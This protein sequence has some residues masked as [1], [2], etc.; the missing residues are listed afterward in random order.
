[1]E[2]RASGRRPLLVSPLL[3]ANPICV[4]APLPGRAL[5]ACHIFAP[6]VCLVSGWRCVSPLPSHTCGLLYFVVG[7]IGLDSESERADQTAD[8]HDARTKAQGQ[9][10]RQHDQPSA[11]MPLCRLR[12]PT[13][14]CASLRSSFHFCRAVRALFVPTPVRKDGALWRGG[15]RGLD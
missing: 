4:R 15:S 11:D 7:R 14:L 13:R 10:T 2:L 6:H 9:G 12:F 3:V 5:S 8:M 1:M